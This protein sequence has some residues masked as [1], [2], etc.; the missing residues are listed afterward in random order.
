MIKEDI[1]N[2]RGG[3]KLQDVVR[4]RSQ[5]Q[6]QFLVLSILAEDFPGHRLKLFPPEYHTVLTEFRM[7]ISP[8]N[9]FVEK[10]IFLSHDYATWT[11][12]KVMPV[13]RYP[14]IHLRRHHVLVVIELGVADNRILR[15][16][17]DM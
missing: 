13:S 2:S 1:G 10:A 12:C 8:S 17:Y 5:V 7:D 14:R 6:V 9:L 4:K 3:E 16:G 15:Q 11:D